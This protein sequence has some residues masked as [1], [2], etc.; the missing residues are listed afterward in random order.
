[1]TSLK[2]AIVLVVML[3]AGTA[4]QAAPPVGVPDA[5]DA[6]SLMYVTLFGENRCIACQNACYRRAEWNKWWC[7][8]SGRSQKWCDDRWS[9]YYGDCK[10][11]CKGSRACLRKR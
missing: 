5:G 8:L 2:A 1:M 11:R 4:A 3:A 10:V 9:D 6:T 7:Q